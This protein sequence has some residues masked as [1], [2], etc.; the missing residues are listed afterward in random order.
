MTATDEIFIKWLTE[1]VS[2]HRYAPSVR[3]AAA[4]LAVNVSSAHHRLE[5]LRREGRITWNEG[6]TRT[7]R[8]TEKERNAKKANARRKRSAQVPV[9]TV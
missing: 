3:E 5:R 2:E 8:L 1:F 9:R 4:F 7:M 6:E